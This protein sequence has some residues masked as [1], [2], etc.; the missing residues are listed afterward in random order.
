MPQVRM[1]EMTVEEVREYLKKNHTIILPYGV[2]EQHGYHLPLDTD[3]RNATVIGEKLAKKLGCLVAPTLNYCFSGG[4]LP[5]T[6]NVKPN[7]FSAMVGEIIESLALQ[8]FRNIIILPGHGGGEALGSLKESLRLQKWFSPVMKE[9]L[10]LLLRI[11]R[12]SPTWQEVAR[13]NHDCHAGL[14][15]TSFILDWFPK[16]VRKERPV[17]QARL[18]KRIS[19]NPDTFLRHTSLTKDPQEIPTSEQ[20]PRIHVG[21]MGH[22]E[23]ASAQLGRKITN[24]IIKNAAKELTEVLHQAETSRRSGKR[25]EKTVTGEV[26]VIAL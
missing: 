15:E 23:K 19:D 8:G 13:Q 6:I 25:F 14:V 11:Y 17:D 18:A 4:T 10:I 16:E 21:V 7:T 22:P 9:T 1:G 12:Y 24:E 2:V 3:I 26:K 5:G 20:D